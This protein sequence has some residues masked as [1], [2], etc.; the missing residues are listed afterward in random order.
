[1]NN[2]QPGTSLSK[3]IASFLSLRIPEKKRN[4]QTPEQFCSFHPEQNHL[5]I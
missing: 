5:E 1:M 2:L 3:P 4:L